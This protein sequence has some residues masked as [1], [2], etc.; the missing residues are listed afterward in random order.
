MGYYTEHSIET[1]ITEE[2]IV[3]LER[4]SGYSRESL[5][6]GCECKWYGMMDNVQLL[7]SKFKDQ[8]FVWECNGEESGDI[9]KVFAKGGKVEKVEA[10]ITCDEPEWVK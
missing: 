9:Y 3:E 6:Y 2:Q 8:L 10:K 4:I 7:S 1:Y 5:L